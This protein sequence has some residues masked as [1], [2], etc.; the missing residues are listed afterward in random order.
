MFLAET[1]LMNVQLNINFRN[2]VEMKVLKMKRT[3]NALQSLTIIN[4]GPLLK[5]IYIEQLERQRRKIR[6]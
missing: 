5:W 1:Q 2:M 4:Q 3:I 6:C